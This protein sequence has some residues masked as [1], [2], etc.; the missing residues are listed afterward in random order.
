ML[1]TKKN[2]VICEKKIHEI[3]FLNIRHVALELLEDFGLSCGLFI[4]TIF[5]CMYRG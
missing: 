1:D 3:C 4:L 2:R 5:I